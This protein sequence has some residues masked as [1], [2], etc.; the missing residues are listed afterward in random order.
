MIYLLKLIALA[1]A[2]VRL[3]AKVASFTFNAALLLVFI[4]CHPRE[5][6]RMVSAQ[7]AGVQIVIIFW[8]CVIVYVTAHHPLS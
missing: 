4:A 1:L 5:M 2:T 3:L 6:L 8:V 7:S